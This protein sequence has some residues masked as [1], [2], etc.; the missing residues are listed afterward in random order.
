MIETEHTIG[1]IKVLCVCVWH[2]ESE[3]L[4]EGKSAGRHWTGEEWMERKI[5]AHGRTLAR[6]GGEGNGTAGG[7]IELP[8]VPRWPS[9]P[10]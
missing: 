8:G 2:C 10:H 9:V 3:D 1:G 7:K 6:H 4:L 5:L